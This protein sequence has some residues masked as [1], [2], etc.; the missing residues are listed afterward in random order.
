MDTLYNSNSEIS[1]SVAAQTAHGKL[2]LL[3]EE[4]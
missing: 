2:S 4:H 1:S 3:S